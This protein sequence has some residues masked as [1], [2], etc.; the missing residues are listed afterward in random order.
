M[1][2]MRKL[3]F[4][5]LACL[6]LFM[7]NCGGYDS[8]RLSITLSPNAATIPVSSSSDFHA[9]GTFGKYTFINWTVAEAASLGVSCTVQVTPPE[10]PPA[11]PPACTQTGGWISVPFSTG[12]IASTNVTYHSPSTPGTYHIDAVATQGNASGIAHATVNVV[13]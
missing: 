8:E 1:G 4:R 6:L 3:Q 9:N 2:P 12:F 10:P 5:C 11:P 7:T 13:P